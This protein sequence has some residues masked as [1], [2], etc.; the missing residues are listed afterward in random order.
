M[1]KDNAFTLAEVMIALVVL[2]V[3]MAL[4]LP[5][6][7]DAMPNKDKMM[8]KK[9]YYTTENVIHDLIN[10]SNLYPDNSNFCNTRYDSSGNAIEGTGPTNPECYFGF[11]DDRKVMHNNKVFEGDTKFPKLFREKL[12]VADA[13]V[14]DDYK[15]VTNDGMKWEI[16]TN[17]G[18]AFSGKDP[19]L[20]PALIIID[21]NGDGD[22]NCIEDDPDS[23][24]KKCNSNQDPDIFRIN[25]YMNG[26]LTVDSYDKKAAEFIK[27]GAKIQD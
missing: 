27:V 11:D 9:A 20:N 7:M 16:Y 1:K 3:I 25:V 4:V 8:I 10:D 14:I 6:I 15:F 2:G 23:T 21:V 22:P 19:A 26:K 24:Q 18:S 12:N 5:V 17:N 13:N